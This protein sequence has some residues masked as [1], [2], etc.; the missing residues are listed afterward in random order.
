MLKALDLFC[1]L[2]GW[3]DGLALEGFEILGVEIEPDI[4]KLYKH[5]VIV[6]DVRELDGEDFQGYDLIV[7]SPPCRDFTHFSYAIWDK[8]NYDKR[9]WKVPPDPEKGLE[10]VNALLRVVKD[11]KP[12]YWLMENVPELKRHLSLKPR[13]DK[14][15][16]APR[17]IRSFWGDFPLF[18]IPQDL[19]KKPYY[20]LSKEVRWKEINSVL[21]YR[22]LLRSFIYA[23]IPLSV[24]RALGK[25]IREAIF[26]VCDK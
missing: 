5:P 19:T 4:A 16:L 1:G 14:V 23:K 21:G 17:M 9:R 20:G 24:A 22:R 2:G 25:T 12:T 15:K 8:P 6:G 11:A 10:L 3:S 13:V 18:F 26:R 7:G